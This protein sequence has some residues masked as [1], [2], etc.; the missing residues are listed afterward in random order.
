MLLHPLR[1]VSISAAIS[2]AIV[3]P[4][5]AQKRAGSS[6]KRGTRRRPQSSQRVVTRCCFALV[7]P[8]T[9]PMALI[10]F[11]VSERTTLTP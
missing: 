11:V 9:F 3:V 10:V 7:M 2:A 5:V 6:G 4:H 1:N 8:I